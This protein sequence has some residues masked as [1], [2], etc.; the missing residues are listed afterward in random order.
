M[1]RPEKT[2]KMRVTLYVDKQTYLDFLH[3]TSK[4]PRG[5]PSLIFLQAIEKINLEIESTGKSS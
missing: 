4:Y 1:S 3:N 5:L 2:D